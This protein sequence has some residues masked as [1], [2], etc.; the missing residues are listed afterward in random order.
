MLTFITEAQGASEDFFFLW[1]VFQVWSKLF[2]L[3]CL[4][5]ENWWEKKLCYPVFLISLII[6]VKRSGK[7]ISIERNKMCYLLWY[8]RYFPR[9]IF[10]HGWNQIKKKMFMRKKHF[11]QL[12]YFHWISFSCVKPRKKEESL[13]ERCRDTPFSQIKC[14]MT[15][16]LKPSFLQ[17]SCQATVVY[18]PCQ[19][20]SNCYWFHNSTLNIKQ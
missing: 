6:C 10:F 16:R 17:C 14:I 7:K 2:S 1:T 13:N 18:A 5:L 15:E 4:G 11:E 3:M 8:N 20:P 19:S 9:E 12:F